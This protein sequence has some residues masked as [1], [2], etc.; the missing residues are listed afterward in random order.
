M[1]FECCSGG[2]RRCSGVT[3]DGADQWR[4]GDPERADVTARMPETVRAALELSVLITGAA[5]TFSE[6]CDRLLIYE[7]K[8]HFTVTS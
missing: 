7:L 1:R 8:V 4:D 5:Q 6:L 2:E 3:G